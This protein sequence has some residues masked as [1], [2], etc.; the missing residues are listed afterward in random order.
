MTLTLPLDLLRRDGPGEEWDPML[1]GRAPGLALAVTVEDRLRLVVLDVAEQGSLDLD[2]AEELK[3]HCAGRRADELADELV[4]G[5][6]GRHPLCE[7]VAIADLWPDGQ[8]QL[9]IR[10]AP[11]AVLLSPD[12]PARL[13]PDTGSPGA[14][15]PIR[16]AEVLLLCSA[17]FL[18][19]PPSVLGAVR[20][21]FFTTSGLTELRRSLQ[22]TAHPGATASIARPTP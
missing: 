1:S 6:S 13:I 2:T 21:S 17:S 3:Q 7:S 4:T 5:R 22:R 20:R 10:N 18:E 12:Q 8:L 15:P 11:S 19:E 14:C 9:R 16:P